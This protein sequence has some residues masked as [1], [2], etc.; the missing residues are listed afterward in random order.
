MRNQVPS[1][2]NLKEIALSRVYVFIQKN[3]FNGT[4]L[5]INDKVKKSFA[6]EAGF[7]MHSRSNVPNENLIN[8]LL[9]DKIIDSLSIKDIADQLI[10]KESLSQGEE[11]VKLALINFELLQGYLEKQMQRRLSQALSWQD[12]KYALVNELPVGLVKMPYSKSIVEIAYQTMLAKTDQ[13]GVDP[14]MV[15][16]FS[17]SGLNDRDLKITGLELNMFRAINGVDSILKISQNT[18]LDLKAVGHFMR[19][20]EN[21]DVI[22]LK[23]MVTQETKIQKPQTEKTKNIEG[24]ESFANALMEKNHY[25]ALG[26]K[27]GAG[28]DQI[29]KAYFAMAKEYHPDRSGTDPREK[30]IFEKIFS[31]ISHAN[32][33]LTDS[34]TKAEYDAQLDLQDQGSQNMEGQ[35]ILESEMLYQKGLALTRKGG[36]KEAIEVLQ[37]AIELYNEEPEYTMLLGWV[38]FKVGRQDKNDSLCRSGK[39]LVENSLRKNS[40]LGQGYYYL[41]QIEKASGHLEKAKEHFEKTLTIMPHHAEASS[42]LRLLG[43]RTKEKKGGLSSLFGK[44]KS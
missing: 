15:P 8:M 42:E 30:K 41:G 13:A 31:K 7:V 33:T 18:R 16:T 3:Q 9:E 26:L 24:L 19:V 10:Q 36:F 21:L 37:N 40:N 35:K 20:M 4:L 12:G 1:S 29:K 43:A 25:E 38:Q 27:K 32:A 5:L 22:A 39:D 2:G 28:L 44:K 23:T 11:L 34:R 17:G 14:S 6:F